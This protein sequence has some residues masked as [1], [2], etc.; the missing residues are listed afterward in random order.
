MIGVELRRLAVF[1]AAAEEGSFTAAARRLKMAQSGVS[2]A[3]R[4][5]EHEFQ[6]TLFDR[7]RHRVELTR[8][9][10]LLLPEAWRTLAAAANAHD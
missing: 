8:T 1:A 3:V 4:A 10:Q 6:V 2:A 7:T 9:G 5:L